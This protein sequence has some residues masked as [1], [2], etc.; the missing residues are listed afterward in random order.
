M[1]DRNESREQ[2]EVRGRVKSGIRILSATPNEATSWN[3][4]VEI[5]PRHTG[6]SVTALRKEPVESEVD[7][8]SAGEVVELFT[9]LIEVTEDAAELYEGARLVWSM[10]L[11]PHQEDG[12]PPES[13]RSD[14]R[15]STTRLDI[16]KDDI[17]AVVPISK[18]L[19]STEACKQ[20]ANKAETAI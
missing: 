7:A 14:S 17:Q 13:H 6:A 11:E 12:E 9:W 4:T 2:I 8:S 18:G 20:N 16:Q 10:K 5:N 19:L 15:K 3:I 1:T